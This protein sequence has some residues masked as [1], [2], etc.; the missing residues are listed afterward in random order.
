MHL[1]DFG[2]EVKSIRRPNS[3]GGDLSTQI[4]LA[5]GDVVVLLGQPAGLTNAQNA[6]LIGR[7]AIK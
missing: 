1:E 2:V 5:E 7:V 4:A 3:N 6:L